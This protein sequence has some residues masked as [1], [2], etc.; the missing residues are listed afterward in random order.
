MR[1][2]DKISSILMIRFDR[3]EPDLRAFYDLKSNESN[4]LFVKFLKIMTKKAF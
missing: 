1:T 2:A 3:T 4:C